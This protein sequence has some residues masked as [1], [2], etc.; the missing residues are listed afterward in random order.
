[1]PVPQ[2]SIYLF[3]LF[4][5][6]HTFLFT[7]LPTRF[8]SVPHQNCW[9]LRA[10]NGAW[11]IFSMYIILNLNSFCASHEEHFHNRER[12]LC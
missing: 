4:L 10:Q 11:K 1:M 9:C 7:F 2:F 6:E 5:Q 8:L 3:I 12:D